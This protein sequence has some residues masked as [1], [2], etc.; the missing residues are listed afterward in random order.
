MIRVRNLSKIFGQNKVLDGVNLTVEQGETVALLGPSGSGKTTLLRCLNG[1]ERFTSGEV[2]VDN[3][4]LYPPGEDPQEQEKLAKIRLCCGFVFQQY[5]LFP[6]MSVLAN[7]A[8]APIHVQGL[9]KAKAEGIALE[10]L[11]RVGLGAKATSKPAR[12][13]GGEQQRVA[14]ARALALQPKYLL[15][16]E[17][18]SALDPDRARDMWELMGR[19]A[20][21]GQTQVIVTHQT[22]LTTH[23]P[24]RVVRMK[25]GQIL[26]DS[27]P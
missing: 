15:Y 18:T 6:H 3:I 16:D 11:D 22:E 2:E 8:L 1:L 7:V 24:C 26:E 14:I 13:S 4:L 23:I 20:Q 12:L 27:K 19:L 5:H 25:A 17:P 10:L 21:D 9:P